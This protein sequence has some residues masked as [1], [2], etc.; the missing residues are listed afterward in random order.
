[1]HDLHLQAGVDEEESSPNVSQVTGPEESA[2]R[3]H[4]LPI[5][6]FPEREFPLGGVRAHRH[7]LK[8]GDSATWT[9]HFL[10]FVDVIADVYVGISVDIYVDESM[11]THYFRQ[12][13]A[14]WLYGLSS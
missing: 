6:T 1:M 4:M 8:L 5:P 3:P 13:Q 10:E 12:F 11:E 9:L 14:I 2:A 7:P